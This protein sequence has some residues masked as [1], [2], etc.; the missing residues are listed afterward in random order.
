M[1]ST[2]PITETE[3]EAQIKELA[4]YYGYI[5]YH[6]W[7]SFHSPAGFPDCVLCRLEP[8]PRLIFAELKAEG[9]QPTIDQWGWLYILQHVGKPVEA[10]LW[11]PA[12]FEEI[13]EVL[14]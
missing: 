14:R 4:D 1:S 5:Y 13:K 10:Y 8:E 11:Y 12:D 3:F 2:V 7:R 6:P 9:N